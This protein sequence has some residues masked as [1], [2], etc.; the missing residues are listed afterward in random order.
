MNLHGCLRK[1]L[2][3]WTS[4]KQ[5]LFKNNDLAKFIRIDFVEQVRR[6]S[7][8]RKYV[9]KASAG[10]GNWA[11]VPWLSIL[12]T[13]V[14]NS[15]QDG[16][17]PVYLFCADGSGVYLSLNQGTTNPREHL[18]K[19]KSEE[20]AR[21]LAKFFIGAIPEL[22]NWGDIQGNLNLKADTSLGRSYELPNIAAKFYPRDNLPENNV[23]EKD[24]R[25]LL[26]I[27][28]D[29]ARLWPEVSD[30]AISDSKVV[31]KG[32]SILKNSS[33]L[34][35][36]DSDVMKF[37]ADQIFLPKPFLLLAGIS[38]TGKTRFVTDQACRSASQYGLKAGDNYCLVPVRPDW[39]EPSDLLGYISR[40]NGT[41]YVAT[42]FLKFIIKA[43]VAAV[44]S[45]DDG[46]IQWKTF[47]DVPPFW[48]CLDE[49]NLAPVEQYF[50]D[51]LSILE[52]REWSAGN[53][54]SR[55]IMSA[56]V[57][58]QLAHCNTD[59][60]DNALD[61][62]WNELFADTACGFQQALG[63]YFRIN[64]I[65]LPPNL[66][67]A[68]TVNM[69]ETTHGFS[70]KVIDRALTIDFQE[71]FPN[72]Y[73]A[74]FAGQKSPKLFTFPVLSAAGEKDLPSIDSD[75][76]GSK[77]I[78]FLKAIN[79]ILINTPFELAYRA[80]NELLLSVSCFAPK[81]DEELQAVWDDFLMQKVL[82]RMEGDGQKLKFVPVD[83]EEAGG[84]GHLKGLEKIY[85]KGT[86]LH[87]LFAVLETNLLK[88]IWGDENESKKRPDLLRDTDDLIECRSKK[89]LL[90]M[91]KRLKANHF[92]DFWV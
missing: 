65:P 86:I 81:N 12:H 40:I 35:A 59:T 11:S 5:H 42:P 62:L 73:D 92:T 17:Y 46:T 25:E 87:Q 61:I 69:D 36:S 51:Y 28:S 50:A 1:I 24:L 66:I 39:H 18:G 55:A 82:P 33:T 10:A 58:Q 72:E 19:T 76:D 6:I 84:N 31:G 26:N 34:G 9:I 30:Y 56:D 68:G 74:F 41:R 4:E 49:M 83:G 23:L 53:Y 80:L 88:D 13:S 45:V 37:G 71:F 32:A 29:V 14:T 27:Y 16:I 48:L 38:G 43:M 91:M 89:K 47:A 52:T 7:E 54:S 44:D 78:D 22:S 15:T 8:D 90:W 75:G 20:R 60:G 79:T 67:V 70:R 2:F 77:S 85:G 63:D 3:E 21:A 57:L 64:G